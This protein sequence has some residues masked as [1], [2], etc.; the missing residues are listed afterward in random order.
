MRDKL[1][2]STAKQLGVVLEG[3]LR[4]CEGCSVAKGLGRPVGRTMS[5]RADN[6]FGR[7]FIDICGEKSIESIGGKRYMLLICDGFSRF[8]WTYFM[9]QKSESATRF[10]QFLADEHVARIPSAVEVVRSDEGG[11]FKGDFAKLCRRHNIRQE[12][13]TADSTKFNGVGERHIA[14]IESAG[15]AAQ[16]QAKPFFCRFKIPSGSRL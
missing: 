8:M 13:T 14:M 4:E 3:S 9:R 1:L 10:R 11:E 5:T 16:V 12:F 7:L 15:M 6:V 2:C